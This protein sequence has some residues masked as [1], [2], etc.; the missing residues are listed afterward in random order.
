MKTNRVYVTIGVIIFVSLFS[1]LIFANEKSKLDYVNDIGRFYLLKSLL[2]EKID[3][4]Y[5][6]EIDGILNLIGDS[7]SNPDSLLTIKQIFVSNHVS[8]FKVSNNS[9]LIMN[10]PVIFAVI[11]ENHYYESYLLDNKN[12]IIFVNKH[13]KNIDSSQEFERVVRLSS[14]LLI[15]NNAVILTKENVNNFRYIVEHY[16]IREN[17]ILKVKNEN[18]DYYYEI[19]YREDNDNVISYYLILFKYEHWLSFEKHLL[20]KVLK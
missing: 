10:E 8:I 12:V 2:K 19:F 16:K 14:K 1:S 3:P 7:I 5:S 15:G 17:D 9:K 18:G 20:F 11:D 13:I 6:T 4:I